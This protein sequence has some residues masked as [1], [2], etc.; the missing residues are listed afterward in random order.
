MVR[1][2]G[3]QSVVELLNAK[4]TPGAKVDAM[5]GNE[6]VFHATDDEFELLRDP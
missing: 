1:K 4:I 2:H 3:F 5:D 6:R